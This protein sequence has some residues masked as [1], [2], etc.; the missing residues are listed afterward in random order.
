MSFVSRD[1][2]PPAEI[3][4]KFNSHDLTPFQLDPLSAAKIQ[5]VP[6][7]LRLMSVTVAGL[8][9]IAGLNRR[10]RDVRRQ[11]RRRNDATGRSR[12]GRRPRR[13]QRAGGAAPARGPPRGRRRAGQPAEADEAVQEACL[14][15][16]RR[17]DR[18]DDPAAFRAWL[19]RITWRKAL[20]RRRSLTSMAAPHPRDQETTSARD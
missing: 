15:A 5:P 17:I 6:R 18:L 4:V 16:W 2:T 1:L 19:L 14:T 7:R 3:S 12:P 9:V 11:F 10:S 20:D 8:T 13:V